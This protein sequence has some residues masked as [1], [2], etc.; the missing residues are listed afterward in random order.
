MVDPTL[1]RPEQIFVLATTEDGTRAALGEAKR[2]SA[3]LSSAPMIV[4]VPRVVS[5]LTPPDG[6][7]EAAAITAQY[8]ALVSRAGADAAVHVCVCRRRDHMLRSM[9][10]RQSIVVLGGRSRW[11]WPTSE[12]QIARDLERMGYASRFVEVP[13]TKRRRQPR[14]GDWRWAR[15][16]ACGSRPTFARS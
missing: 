5:Y 6:P 4:L 9:M 10:S 2:L 13:V 7:E 14:G 3:R 16:A 12:Q 11:W 15:I 8:R 1:D